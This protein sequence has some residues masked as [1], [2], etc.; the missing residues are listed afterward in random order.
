MHMHG[1]SKLL[2]IAKLLPRLGFLN[3]FRVAKHRVLLKLRIHPACRLQA[4]IVAG[5][6]FQEVS[7][8]RALKTSQAWRG[9]LKYFD[10]FE[11]PVPVGGKPNWFSKPFS[12]GAD[13]PSDGSWWK[14]NAS[15]KNT[16]D[17]K[18]VWD[19]SRFNWVLA[20]AQR[21]AIGESPELHRLN[22]WLR[23][24]SEKNPPY[25][26]PNWGCG[27][28]ASIRVM[29][30]ATAAVIL[31]QD[32]SPSPAVLSFIRAH[33]ARIASTLSYALSQ[34]N[35]HGVLEA[36]GLFVGGEWLYAVSGDTHARKWA[37]QGRKWL[38]E[39]AR[40]LISPDGGFSMYSVAYHRE[41]L[42]ALTI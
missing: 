36:S 40:K 32:N 42:D 19:L 11:V 38:E 25:T 20:M 2:G 33:L 28:E 1:F 37:D 39:R 18:E 15:I 26:G 29:H 31:G 41:F 8:V 22:E 5:D 4:K 3:I 6:F 16:G 21:V 35:N 14:P 13:W 9:T 34:D 10:W 27:Q 24:W 30:L 12:G 7:N 17:I 23:D